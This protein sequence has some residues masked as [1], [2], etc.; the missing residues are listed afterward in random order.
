MNQSQR[1]MQEYRSTLSPAEVLA[2][3][4][5]FFSA[6]NNIYATFLEQ[7][8]PTY[9]T[10]RG[11]GTEELVIGAIEQNGA[12]LVTGST[13]LFDMQVARFFSTL[14]AF[15]PAERLLPPGPATEL[16]PSLG[17]RQ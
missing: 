13:Y 6:R 2:Q 7:E 10:F 1:T 4:K 9:V 17:S 16:V 11:Q 8:G 14:P 5:K 3:A 15:E 12:T